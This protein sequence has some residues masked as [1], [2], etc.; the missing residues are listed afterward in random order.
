MKTFLENRLTQTLKNFQSTHPAEC[1]TRLEILGKNFRFRMLLQAISLLSHIRV[2]FHFTCLD[3]LSPFFHFGTWRESFFFWSEYISLS[4]I[5]SS[6][7]LLS[8][9]PFSYL[10]RR[11]YRKGWTE[12]KAEKFTFEQNL[13][14]SKPLWNANNSHNFQQ[15]FSILITNLLLALYI[16][17]IFFSPQFQGFQ[18][19]QQILIF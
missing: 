4:P 6:T 16:P 5:P 1:R 9:F 19:P 17:F 2:V 14:L 11:N 10:V 15:K 7:F 18:F 13:L 12:K 3:P 8:S